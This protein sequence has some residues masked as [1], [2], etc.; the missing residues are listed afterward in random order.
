M[1]GPIEPLATVDPDLCAYQVIDDDDVFHIDALNVMDDVDVDITERF[2]PKDVP[3][4]Q[5]DT[6][7]DA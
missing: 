1:N 6:D 7:R 2:P 4:D 3:P 5:L